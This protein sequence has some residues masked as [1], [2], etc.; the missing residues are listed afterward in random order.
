MSVMI[1]KEKVERCF[2]SSTHT[3][4]EHATVQ[5]MIS[6][7]LINIIGKR[8]DNG[9][10]TVLEIGAGTG[11]LTRKLLSSFPISN[12][13]LNDLVP[14]MEVILSGV[15]KPFNVTPQFAMGD[16]ETRV[17]QSGNDLIIS[18]SS[19]QWFSDT[20]AFIGKM[21]SIANPGGIIA[22]STFAP[23]NLHEVK[24][25]TGIGLEYSPINALVSKIPSH[26]T[27]LFAHE[28]CIELHFDSPI[29]VLKHL[30]MTGVNG[31]SNKRWTRKDHRDFMERY[32]LMHA[33]GDGVKLTYKPAYLVFQ[34][35]R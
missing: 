16:A 29:S 9:F 28:E 32:K 30:Q 25:I 18:A 4:N 33:S 20:S 3:Y 1:D 24:Q 27:I 11:L 23:G 21:V 2:R 5:D 6:S 13:V 10:N 14:E 22:I 15:C 19:V 35:G 8:H 12:L 34:L 17:F 31:I 7:Q 26:C